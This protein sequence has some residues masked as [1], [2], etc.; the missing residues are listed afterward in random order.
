[1]PGLVGRFGKPSYGI[2]PGSRTN[3]AHVAV[4]ADENEAEVVQVRARGGRVI[5]DVAAVGQVQC[6][7][8]EV[9][10][11]AAPLVGGGVARQGAPGDGVDAR[12]VVNATARLGGVAGDGAVRD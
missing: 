6:A 7:G 2:Q 3:D 4:A 11:D 8:V 12:V 5:T 9:V 10:E 1:L